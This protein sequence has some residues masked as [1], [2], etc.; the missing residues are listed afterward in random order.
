VLL[1]AAVLVTAGCGGGDG[2]GGTADAGGGGDTSP[3]LPDADAG[4]AGEDVPPAGDVP[5]C[6]PA[7]D[8]SLCLVCDKGAC[9][10]ACGPDEVC[11]PGGCRPVVACDE[12][13]DCTE[14]CA[15]CDETAGICV[16]ACAGTEQCHVTAAGAACEVP[17]ACDCGPCEDCDTADV[18]APVCASR[19]AAAERCHVTAAGAACE[20]P[21]A[22]DC[23]PCEDCDPTD[24]W[25]PVCAP[26]CQG[27]ERCHVTA[28]GAAC[29]VPPA[30][31]CRPCEACDQ[32]D[33]WAPRCVPQCDAFACQIC[34]VARDTC[35]SA[36]DPDACEV[37]DGARAC[38]AACDADTQYC[39]AGACLPRPVLTCDQ[40]DGF[41]DGSV[42]DE[43]VLEAAPASGAPGC[44]CDLDDDGTI[45][46]G[47]ATLI[48]IAEPFLGYDRDYFNEGIAA[49]I[50]AGTVLLAIEF[51]GLD[52][53][54]DDDYL[55]FNAYLA[56]DADDDLTNNFTGAGEFWVQPVSLG[57]D[58]EPLMSFEGAT[59]TAGRLVGGP[60][61]F[62]MPLDLV[63][64]GSPLLL[65]VEHATI[66]ADISAQGAGYALADGQVC[67]WIHR[68]KIV[69]TVNEFISGSCPCLEL[70]GD[71]LT[72]DGALFRCAPLPSNRHC[73]NLDFLGA[74][75][76]QL[77]ESCPGLALLV[78]A[79]LDLDLTEDGKG[80][81]ISL[82][83]SLGAAGAAIV[84]VE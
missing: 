84:G 60:A 57:P 13:A 56:R 27:A 10:S 25:A 49:Q 1:L 29:E 82:G 43:L 61:T 3:G 63:G 9:V 83:V 70:R 45:D 15:T 23:A 68:E 32:T 44:C 73:S 16:S 36:C 31:G 41:C 18:W 24:V 5:G 7:C 11:S 79:V 62:L 6:V 50:A 64:M 28:A 77:A 2:G 8:P 52:D 54:I 80:D 39:R 20:V 65:S 51:L 40:P 59:I 48:D 21:P 30:C 47:L 37:C 35:V 75:C 17:P 4:P 42:I 71:L 81:A 72:Y 34:D 38:T 74:T 22:C 26:R 69:T 76:N 19:C 53:M 66:S 78:P 55:T 33:L 46:N 12:D 58:G 14:P 67:G